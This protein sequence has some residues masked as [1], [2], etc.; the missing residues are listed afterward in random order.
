MSP[1]S[2]YGEKPSN[3][4]MSVLKG[5]GGS[6]MTEAQSCRRYKHTRIAPRE[7]FTL[8]YFD[9]RIIYIAS[10]LPMNPTV[11]YHSTMRQIS[12]PNAILEANGR[13]NSVMGNEVP[14]RPAKP[15]ESYRKISALRS[16]SRLCCIIIGNCF[17]SALICLCLWRFSKIDKLTRWQKRGF[18]TLALLLSAA[19][20]FGIGFLFDQVGL[21]ARGKVL[22]GGPY[23][24]EGV[25][26]CHPV[27]NAF[28]YGCMFTDESIMHLGRLYIAG[29]TTDIHLII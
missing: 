24:K 8:S 29:D 20:G 14:V 25:C 27:V 17:C 28:Y 19:L 4:G 26:A 1:A 3:I 18:N 10:T 22:Q 21:M 12:D 9:Q 11:G 23:S 7:V 13:P 2:D 16:A 5:C 15:H 6:G